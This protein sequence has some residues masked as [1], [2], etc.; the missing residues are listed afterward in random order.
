MQ[1]QVSRWVK[2]GI[3]ATVLL[4]GATAWAT[5]GHV[6]FTLDDVNKNGKLV[7]PGTKTQFNYV[8]HGHRFHGKATGKVKNA[9]VV[10][11]RPH[12]ARFHDTGHIKGFT[13]L[14]DRTV[15]RIN[16]NCTYVARG[17]KP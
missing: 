12:V 5:T 13:I 6:P 14:S 9:Y 4:V 3:V 17:T 11:G 1:R 2:G 15:V 10:N 7:G 16:G 8:L